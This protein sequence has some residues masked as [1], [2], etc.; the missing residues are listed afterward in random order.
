MQNRI[1][2]FPLKGGLELISVLCSSPILVPA[3]DKLKGAVEVRKSG[4][5]KSFLILVMST[6]GI[7]SSNNE[8]VFQSDLNKWKLSNISS[9]QW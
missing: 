9:L 6:I 8:A 3:Q 1:I 5:T 7:M 4:C 2:G